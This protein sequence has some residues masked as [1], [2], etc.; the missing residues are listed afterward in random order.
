[1]HTIY[2]CVWIGAWVLLCQIQYT[3]RAIFNNFD[4]TTEIGVQ[5]IATCIQTDTFLPSN[6]STPASGRSL[7]QVIGAVGSTTRTRAEE[8][9]PKKNTEEKKKRDFFGGSGREASQ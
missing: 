6:A 9:S 1:M 3:I 8:A 4:F 7:R 2:V 5:K